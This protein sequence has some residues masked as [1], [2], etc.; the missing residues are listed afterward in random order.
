MEEKDRR[1]ETHLKIKIHIFCVCLC[2]CK[3]TQEKIA[4]AVFLSVVLIKPEAA[5]DMTAHTHSLPLSSSSYIYFF[6]LSP[7]PLI[8]FFSLTHFLDKGNIIKYQKYQ[9]TSH[10]DRMSDGIVT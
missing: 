2:L 5:L 6:H 9:I 7:R 4:Y 10:D 3:G 8:C 1:L